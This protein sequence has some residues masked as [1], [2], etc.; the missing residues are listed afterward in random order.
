MEGLGMKKVGT[1][2]GHYKYFNAT[3]LVSFIALWY[4]LWFIWHIFPFWYVAPVKIW[5]P[6]FQVLLCC[7][8]W[9]FG[10]PVHLR[11]GWPD[12]FV[13]KIRPKCGPTYFFV[14]LNT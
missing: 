8:L 10:G 14:K 12:E 2:Y 11:S 9:F 13:K 6:R 4:I 5:Q 3:C 7:D 1:F